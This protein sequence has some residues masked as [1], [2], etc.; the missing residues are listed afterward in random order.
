MCRGLVQRA[1][2]GHAAPYFKAGKP[3]TVFF[4]EKLH[5]RKRVAMLSVRA[6]VSLSRAL[7]R[8]LSVIRCP[9]VHGD[10]GLSTCVDHCKVAPESVKSMSQVM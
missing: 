7:V 3:P 2:H 9:C 1:A 10:E 8:L 6:L 4:P 5:E